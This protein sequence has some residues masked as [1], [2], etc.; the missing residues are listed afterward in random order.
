MNVMF[1]HVKSNTLGSN[2]NVAFM[3]LNDFFFT[4]RT[5]TIGELVP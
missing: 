4:L 2:Q 3:I 1:S 5:C